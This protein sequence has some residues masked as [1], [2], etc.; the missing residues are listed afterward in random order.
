MNIRTSLAAVSLAG[1]VLLSGC[2]SVSTQTDLKEQKNDAVVVSGDYTGPKKRV[3]VM[4]FDVP[5][6]Y[7]DNYPELAEKRI[8]FGLCNRLVDAFYET[9]RFD[10]IEEKQA[11]IDRMLQSWALSQSG[12]VNEETAV[13]SEG[14][15]APE[16]LVYAEV[17][18][19]S[20][21]TSESIA[22]VAARQD[23]IT[24]LGI[25]VRMVDVA[26]GQYVPSSGIGEVVV[27]ENAVI[28]A[29]NQESFDQSTVGKASQLAINTAVNTLVKRLKF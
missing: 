26:T 21:S 25:Q 2:A 6:K 16:Y 7:L 20:V 1:A 28:W 13:Q 12:A 24:R 4:Q 29:A 23:K 18:D 9:N 27:E 5:Q 22:G 15:N 19:F 17:Y 14:L 3:Q 10:F 8:G 11:I